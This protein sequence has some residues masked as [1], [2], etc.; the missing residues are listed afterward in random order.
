MP[1]NRM[2]PTNMKAKYSLTPRSLCCAEKLKPIPALYSVVKMYD[3]LNRSMD[4]TKYQGTSLYVKCMYI[5]EPSYQYCNSMAV[6]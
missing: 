1:L 3:R 2:S 4:R 5:I 6:P